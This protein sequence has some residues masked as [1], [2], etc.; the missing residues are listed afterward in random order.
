MIDREAD[1]LDTG[2]T[3]ALEDDP[4]MYPYSLAVRLLQSKNWIQHAIHKYT[5]NRAL[6]ENVVRNRVKS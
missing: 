6:I 4:E 3:A 5:Y 2:L 1:T